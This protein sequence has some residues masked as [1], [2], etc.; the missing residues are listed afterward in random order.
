MTAEAMLDLK[1]RL[2][3]LSA[4]DRRT[5]A[6]YFLR[7]KD[8]SPAGRKEMSRIMKEMDQGKKFRLTDLMKQLGHG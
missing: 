7:L 8:E 1:Q 4:A 5:M 3:K 2:S 6:A